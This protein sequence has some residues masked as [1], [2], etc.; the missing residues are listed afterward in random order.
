MA[1]VRCSADGKGVGYGTML[2]RIERALRFGQVMGVPVL[3]VRPAKSINT[4][5]FHLRSDDVEIISPESWRALWLK[6]VWFATA[7]FR[8]GSPW[9]WTRRTVARALLGPVYEGVERSR[10]LPRAVRRFVVRPRPIY[11][12]LRAANAAYAFLSSTLWRQTFKQQASK[13]LRDAEHQ[14]IE[15]PL[16]LALPADRERAVIEQASALGIGL[17]TPL[18]TVHVHE[19]GYRSAA[20][21]RQRRWDV[22]RNAQIE[23]CFEAFSAL[24][25]RGYT[26]VRHCQLGLLLAELPYAQLPRIPVFP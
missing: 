16:R 13:R 22:L 23:T 25:E 19:S 5:V 11:R 26:V 21:L 4:A 14:G 3:F 1:D 8:I 6:C 17:T 18:V 12:R 9:L 2:I 20:G 24:V 15:M 7:P 10:Y